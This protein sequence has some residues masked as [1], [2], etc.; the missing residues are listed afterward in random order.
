MT[1]EAEIPVEERI[2]QLLHHLGIERTHIAASTP[3][4]WQGLVTA[5]PELILSLTLVFPRTIDPGILKT[6]AP[7][8][9]VF[10]GGMPLVIN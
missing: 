1:T 8:L 9:L 6:L 2:L 5:Y 7:R 4:D 3:S 10:S